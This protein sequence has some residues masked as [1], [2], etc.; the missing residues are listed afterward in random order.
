[1]KLKLKELNPNP[2]KRYINDGKLSK[3]RVELLK[4]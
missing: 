3:E 1:M 2:F 4:E